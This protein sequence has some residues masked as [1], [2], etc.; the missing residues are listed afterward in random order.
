MVVVLLASESFNEF[1]GEKFSEL[2]MGPACCGW[3]DDHRRNRHLL[4]GVG[5][6]RR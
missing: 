1:L 4:P 2:R 6:C 5:L 3:F